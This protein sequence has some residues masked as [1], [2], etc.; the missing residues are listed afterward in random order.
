MSYTHFTLEERK[1]L[2]E[3][4]AEGTH[5]LREIANI[6]ERSPSTISREIKRNRSQHRS[7]RKHDNKYCYN[8]WRAQNLYIRRR[9][10]QDRQKLKPDSAAWKFIVK[11]LK[12]YWP[13]K[14]I[15]GRWHA[16]Y[17]DREKLC[18]STIYRYIKL[19]RFP[20]IRRKTHLRR[21]GKK[22]QTR[23]ANYNAIHPDRIIPEWT[24]EIRNRVRIGD[25]EGDTVYGGIGKGLLVTLVDRK[26]RYV[27]I[28]LLRHREA[29][30]TRLV[31]EKLLR[32]RP[33][34]SISLDN[35]T[36]F[37]EFRKLESN[38]KAPVYFAEP[39]KPWQRG[40]NENTNDLI[41]F[42]FPKGF[43]FRTVT[44][45]DI[46]RVEDLLNHRPR[47]CLGWKTP[48]EVFCESVALA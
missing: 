24:D 30:E 42:F 33:V 6:L 22:I 13:P 5:S 7:Y 16:Q 45:E 38:L 17:P 8:H 47:K 12:K 34:E 31:I 41:R 28:G 18:F 19:K 20:N 39:H 40:T 21:R 1:Y 35:G 36:E 15:C 14:T 3:L 46:Q 26:S 23:N 4:L 37:A 43:D 27:R 48:Y 9:R 32:D 10:G 44:D 29:E 2:Q 11:R 25:W